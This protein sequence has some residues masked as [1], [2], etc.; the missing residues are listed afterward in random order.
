M[1]KIEFKNI[2]F[3][4]KLLYLG[5]NPSIIKQMKKSH[6]KRYYIWK[7]L[8][9]FRCCQYYRK[10]RQDKSASR[11]ERKLAKFKFKHYEKKKN[12]YSY[13]SGVEI[14]IDS[15]IGKNCDIWHSG[16]VIN[17]N[18]GD[19]CIFHGNNTI[20]NKGQGNDSLRPELGNNIDI[21]VGAVIIGS[22]IIAD[23]CIIGAGAVV[24]K[25]FEQNNSIIVGVPGK[26]IN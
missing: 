16:V 6:H 24:T 14:G 15:K 22:L 23:G 26:K 21:G 2:I 10:V 4:E 13:K 9:F 17:G 12:I 19:N 11:F 25:S 7:Y 5:D 1:N 3:E 20:G 8:Y 18:I